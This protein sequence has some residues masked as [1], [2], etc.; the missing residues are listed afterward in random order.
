MNLTIVANTEI[1]E[2]S[3]PER[4]NWRKLAASRMGILNMSKA[5]P[6]LAQLKIEMSRVRR[7]QIELNRE[8]MRL[9]L[10]M[11][12]SRWNDYYTR[13]AALRER[14]QQIEAAAIFGE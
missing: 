2:L 14:E 7:S 5:D 3:R 12:R 1:I 11:R 8:M 6:F 4:A 13:L 10:V 9:P